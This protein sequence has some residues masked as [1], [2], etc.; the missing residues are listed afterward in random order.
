MSPAALWAELRRL[1]S[2]PEAPER[3]P[4][5]PMP[6]EAAFVRDFVEPQRPAVFTGYVDRWPA[7]S[8]WTP[9]RLRAEHG[10]VVVPV[11]RTPR[12]VVGGRD[13]RVGITYLELSLAEAL[14]RV[15]AGSDPGHYVVIPVQERLPALL[16]DV[17]LPAVAGAASRLKSRLW[18][19]AAGTVS[20][21]HRDFPDN[22]FAQLRGR[23]RLHILAPRDDGRVYEYP[24]LSRLPRF[25]A[26]DPEA[27]DLRRFPRYRDARPLV[28]DLHPGDLLY[29]PGRWW[30]Q[31][32]S[33]D[34]S[35]SV[36]FWWARGVVKLLTDGADAF[37]RLRRVRL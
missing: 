18:V 30:H 2:R 13:P 29:L 37:K 5:L 24:F 8:R 11:A 15:E 1:T 3:I 21:L 26:V 6:S 12:G 4:R 27:P 20:P 35:V 10:Q 17:Q 36:N 19:S 25:C 14:D 7:F 34:A 33:L 32:R 31:V 16:D 9:E 23:K 22:L 28:V